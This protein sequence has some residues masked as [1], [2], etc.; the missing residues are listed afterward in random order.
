[1]KDESQGQVHGAGA[2]HVL[3][4][5]APAPDF[6]PSSFFRGGPT[7]VVA[8]LSQPACDP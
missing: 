4:P 2:G 3:L 7:R 1:M 5:A 8:P 6:H